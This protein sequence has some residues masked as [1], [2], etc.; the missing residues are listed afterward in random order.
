MQ[1]LK[2]AA[3][4][5]EGLL[6][7]RIHE[8]LRESYEWISLPQ[9]QMD[10]TD[11]HAVSSVLSDIDYDL[12]LHLA[13]YTHVDKAETE[14]AIAEAINVTGTQNLFNEITKKG[15]KMIYISTD[16]VFDGTDGPYYEDSKPHP[17]SVY[18]RTKYQ[19][20]E[21]VKGTGMIVRISYPYGGHVEHK[22]DL[23][24]TLKDL[25]ERKVPIKG[26]TDQSITPTWIDDIAYALDHLMNNFS[27]EIF[28]VTGPQSMSAFE[29]IKLIG[30]A[31]DL[32]T[33]FVGETS[34]EE[35]YTG[36]AR[37]PQHAIMKTH[38]NTFHTMK[39]PAEALKLMEHNS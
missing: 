26:V 8:L 6:G 23:I 34:F 13:A 12:L 38:M 32:D 30:E 19:G 15:K 4:G 36:K 17:I 5:L 2:I 20:E 3:T 39:A 27:P 35:F 14:S 28:H 37:R 9:S 33:S 10:I 22:K 29:L 31:Y 16:F 18:G 11:A 25:I 21:I 7:T 24:A 1:K